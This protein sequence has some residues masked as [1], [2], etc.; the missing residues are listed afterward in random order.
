MFVFHTRDGYKSPL[1][2]LQHKGGK[3]DTKIAK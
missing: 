2:F 1:T 3:R